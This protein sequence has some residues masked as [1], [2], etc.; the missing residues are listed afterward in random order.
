M[1]RSLSCRILIILK[2]PAPRM[3]GRLSSAVQNL[4]ILVAAP[5]GRINLNPFILNSSYHHSFLALK[6]TP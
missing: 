1:N 6:L 2:Q 4:Q 3:L 5:Y